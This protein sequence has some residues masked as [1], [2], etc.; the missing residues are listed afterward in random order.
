[1][2]SALV[3]V[4]AH[5]A[6]AEDVD[7]ADLVALAPTGSTFAVRLIPHN[8]QFAPADHT[9]AG[10]DGSVG[11]RRPEALSV[12]WTGPRLKKTGVQS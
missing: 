7:L 8:A 1:M 10:D 2:K 9:E 6:V 11:R 12:D 5:A 3:P 4:L